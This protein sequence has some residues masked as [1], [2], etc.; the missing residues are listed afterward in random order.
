M[1]PKIVFYIITLPKEFVKT[2]KI[3]VNL[4]VNIRA[5]VL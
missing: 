3:D 5:K 1:G 4:K 2:C